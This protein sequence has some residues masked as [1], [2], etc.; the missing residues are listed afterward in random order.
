MTTSWMSGTSMPRAATSVATSTRPEPS[1]A[2]SFRALSRS[3]CSM[4]NQTQACEEVQVRLTMLTC[5]CAR[6]CVRGLVAV[7]RAG[8]CWSHLGTVSVYTV[9]GDGVALQRHAERLLRTPAHNT[10]QHTARSQGTAQ[11]ACALSTHM[12]S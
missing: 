6:V 9:G 11:R 10:T 7:Q 8:S 2:K 3:F 12:C 5:V 1:T 4:P